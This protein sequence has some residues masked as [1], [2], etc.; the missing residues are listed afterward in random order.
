MEDL[1]RSTADFSYSWAW[2]GLHDDPAAWKTSMGNES[3]SWRWSATGEHSRTGFQ[4]WDSYSPD[5]WKGEETCV[6]MDRRGQWNDDICGS[7][8]SFLCF[9]VTDQN[10]KNYIFINQAMSWSSAQQYCR[11]NYKDLAM[12]ENQEENMEAQN[13]KPSSSTVWIGLY[14]EP[15]TWSDGSLSSF[16][17]WEPSGLNNVNES[18]HCVTENPQHQWADEFCDVPW[19]FVCHQV[20][21]TERKTTLRLKFNTD[22]DM[23]DPKVKAQILEQLQLLLSSGGR[24]DIKLQWKIE[25]KK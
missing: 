25:P 5:Y 22:A 21:K 11:T 18:Q 23:T 1:K 3:N 14:R 8:Y 15:W 9:N 16:T 6:T 24:T 7:S 12:I 4:S 13:A 2:I 17:N 10:N 19:V 20:P